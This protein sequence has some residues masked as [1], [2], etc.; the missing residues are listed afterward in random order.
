KA[1]SEKVILRN[2]KWEVEKVGFNEE[3][4]I[5]VEAVLPEAYAHKTRVEFDLF[6]K[7]PDGPESSSRCQGYIESGTAHRRI[8]AHIPNDRDADGH[9]LQKVGYC[10]AARHSESDPLAGSKA[11]KLVDEMAERV[12]ACHILQDVTFATGK[13]FLRPK[14]AP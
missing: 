7:T 1:P 8:P 14:N 4:D 3:T 6:A 11:P 5:S 2:P 9:V 12:L 10:F 13:S